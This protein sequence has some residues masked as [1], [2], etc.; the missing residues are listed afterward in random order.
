MSRRTFRPASPL[1]AGL[2]AFVAMFAGSSRYE[3]LVALSDDQ[4]AVRGYSRA[5]LTRSFLS[6]RAYS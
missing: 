6:G 3:S 1:R 5:G 2:A 4:L